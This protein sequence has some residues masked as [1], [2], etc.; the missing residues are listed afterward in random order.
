MA[1]EA[2]IVRQ[3]LVFRVPSFR[4]DSHYQCKRLALYAGGKQP[5]L[6]RGKHGIRPSRAVMRK[7]GMFYCGLGSK[8]LV[9]PP[10][11][12]QN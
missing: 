1:V 10:I 12:K 7:Q 5:P 8:L 6:Q 4:Q 9:F 11:Q 3:I 2:S